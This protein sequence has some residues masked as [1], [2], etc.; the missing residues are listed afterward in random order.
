M[1]GEC[2]IHPS[3]GDHGM[4]RVRLLL[5]HPRLGGGG[6]Q[7]VMTLLAKEL[8]QDKYEVHLGL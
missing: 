5:L 4:Q 3:W 2:R 1:I 8:P 7:H 6:S